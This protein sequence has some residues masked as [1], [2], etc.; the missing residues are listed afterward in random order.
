MYVSLTHCTTICPVNVSSGPMIQ[1]VT[2]RNHSHRNE[3]CALY[4]NALQ[5]MPK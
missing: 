4:Y 2:L 5:R 1:L 3:F